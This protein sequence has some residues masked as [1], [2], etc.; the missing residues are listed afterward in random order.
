[1]HRLPGRLLT[2][3]AI[4]ILAAQPA[5]AHDPAHGRV[6]DFW[7]H[8]KVPGSASGA[9]SALVTDNFTVLGHANLGGGVPNG[10]VWFFNHGGSVGKFAYVGTWS[11]QCTG[12]GAK[13]IDVNDP[14]KPK[15]TGFV[16]ARKGSSNEDVVVARI[17]SRDVLAIGVQPCGRGGQSGLALYDVTN[18]LRPSELSFFETPSGVHELDLVVK[19]DG[20]ALA[21]MA[22][23]FNEAGMLF[24]DDHGGEVWIANITNPTTPAYVSDWGIM[25]DSDLVIQGGNDEVTSSFQGLGFFAATFAHSVRFADAGSALYASYWDAGF[26]K[27][28]VANPAAPTLVG[29]TVYGTT[30]AGDGHSLTTYD[31]GGKRY[32]LANDEDFAGIPE[33]IAVRTSALPGAEFPGIQEPWAP[34]SLY[35]FA[36]GTVTAA[37][38]DAGTGCAAADYVGASEKIALADSVDPFYPDD[39]GPPLCPIGTQ[40]TLAAQAGAVAFVS[41]LISFDDPWPFGPDADVSATAGM[42]ILQIAGIDD[43]AAAI[44]EAPESA[45]VTLTATS[46]QPPT[47]GHLRVYE[48]TAGDEW[49]QVGEFMGPAEGPNTPPGSWSIHNT[50]VLGD[51][52]YSSWYSAGIVALD[53]SDPTNPVPAGQFVPN[54][55]K[56]YANSLGTGPAEVWGVAIDPDTGMIYASDMRTGLWIVQPTGDAAP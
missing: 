2:L 42:P 19:P 7:N 5:L 24:G 18:P 11:A 56:R 25:G 47:W 34:T 6:E 10:D 27:L 54:T 38:H 46:E 13:I 31:V 44:R 9:A 32:L 48:E 8:N 49:S 39:F 40:A 1:M 45:S 52:A 3:L 35:G 20:T 28:D 53:V 16:G 41:N 36:G 29:R 21:A 55:S 17:G 26:V 33:T 22:L 43:V 14:T 37:V 51:R 50:E 23:P 15:W 12:Q 4:L 30:D